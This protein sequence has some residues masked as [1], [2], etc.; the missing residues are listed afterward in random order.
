MLY[1]YL[2]CIL[3]GLGLRVCASYSD[4]RD[5]DLLI[6]MAA[7]FFVVPALFILYESTKK[8]SQRSLNKELFEYAKMQID[9][10]LLSVISQ[11]MKRTYPYDEYALN[12]RSVQVFLKNNRQ[13]LKDKLEASEYLGFQVLKDWSES[14]ANTKKILENPFILQSLENEQAIIIVRIM[15]GLTDLEMIQKRLTGLYEVEEKDIE[16][17]RV[18]CGTEIDSKTKFTD[19]YILLKHLTGDKFIVR[20]FGDIP[21]YKLPSVLKI[22]RIKKEYVGLY[23]DVLYYLISEIDNWLSCTGYEVI[24]DPMRFKG[25]LIKVNRNEPVSK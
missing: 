11:L 15:Q 23:S 4:A 13:N 3:G 14:I 18:Q 10:E 21:L 16:G 25:T 6:N 9:S 17:Y 7:A 1:P 5:S 12:E 20:D 24:I 22:C 19:R 2:L 8:A